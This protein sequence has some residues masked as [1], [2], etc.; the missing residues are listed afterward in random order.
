MGLAL[1]C[2]ALN[3]LASAPDGVSQA[4]RIPVILDTDIGDD[5]DDTWA[6]ALLLSSPELDLKLVVGDYGKAEYRARL[7]ARFLETARRTDVPVGM[8]LDIEPRGGGP[9]DQWVKDYSLDSYP[10]RVHKDGVQA[11]IDTIMQSRETIT[12]I[13]I[14]PL[15]NIAAA[16]K[17]EPK[18]AQRARF[19]GMHG[20]VRLGYGGSTNIAAEWNVRAAPQAC[21]AVFQAPW[22]MTITPLDTCGLVTLAGD[23]YARVRDAQGPVAGA[24]IDN[25]R[26][27]SKHSNPANTAADRHS[28]VLF[29][30][31]AVYLA[32]ANDL[33]AMERLN[34]R[35]TDQGLTVLDNGAKAMDVATSWKN[36][37]GFREL[38]VRRLTAARRNAAP[39]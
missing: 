11:L 16:L 25:Y 39:R 22:Q 33:C 4:R 20:S 1:C 10:G 5:I 38:L 13:A 23:Q 3:T 7:L 6:L 18:I 34:L 8:G 15:P 9:Q 14:G 28:S 21:Q 37:D 35:V 2:L 36:L 26:F 32:F 17:R 29:D 12:L 24:V 27:W 30:T 31:V 19:V